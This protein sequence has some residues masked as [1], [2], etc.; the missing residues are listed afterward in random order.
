M[1]FNESE[2]KA[3]KL[4]NLKSCFLG[5]TYVV[6]FSASSNVLPLSSVLSVAKGLILIYLQS[7]Y[8]PRNK[9]RI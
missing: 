6:M 7:Y 3:S 4:E 2:E 5:N 1:I 8:C 9:A